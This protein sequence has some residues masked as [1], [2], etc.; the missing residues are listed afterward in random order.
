MQG[1]GFVEIYRSCGIALG[2]ETV[3]KFQDG[4]WRCCQPKKLKD[5]MIL[6]NVSDEEHD[7]VLDLKDHLDA[8]VSGYLVDL[9][10]DNA[11]G[12]DPKKMNLPIEPVAG[13][14]L[15]H[16]DKYYA[17]DG[18]V[19]STGPGIAVFVHQVLFDADYFRRSQERVNAPNSCMN[20]GHMSPISNA[21][22]ET[23]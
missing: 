6:C 9:I 2:E 21:S 19:Q 1:G 5:A 14:V 11:R 3:E 15:R 10:V 7:Q 13:Q 23:D 20:G 17:I 8:M 16:Q 12:D 4:E 22:L 18:V